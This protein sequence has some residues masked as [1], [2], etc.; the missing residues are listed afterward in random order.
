MVANRAGREA[1]SALEGS[2]VNLLRHTQANPSFVVISFA[3]IIIEIQLTKLI[4]IL[5]VS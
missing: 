2:Q 3:I 1:I 5:I 4:K